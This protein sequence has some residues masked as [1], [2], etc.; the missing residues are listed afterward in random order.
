MAKKI[1]TGDTAQPEPIKLKAAKPTLTKPVK[2]KPVK[3]SGEATKAAP[4]K[5]KSSPRKP[6]PEKASPKKAPSRPRKQAAAPDTFSETIASLFETA[7]EI[8][9]DRLQ[10]SIDQIKAL[11]A[12][13]I[14]QADKKA[15]KAQAK[16][17]KATRNKSAK[18]EA[19][20]TK[21]AKPKKRK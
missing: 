11:A 4:A 7:T 17:A 21:I 15:R 18:T 5:A 14:G 13:F 1:S 8:L 10:P 19:A 16:A 20:P 3:P 9:A 2:P 12:E 6:S